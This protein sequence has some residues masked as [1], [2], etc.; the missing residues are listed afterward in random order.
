MIGGNCAI[1]CRGVNG[2]WWEAFGDMAPHHS[3][4]KVLGSWRPWEIN[5][6]VGYVAS[7]DGAIRLEGIGS[8]MCSCW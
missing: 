5:V 1:D 7:V 4:S 6:A 8:I 3:D 2:R